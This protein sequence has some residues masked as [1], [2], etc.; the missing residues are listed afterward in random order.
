MFETMFTENA[1][2]CT[3][4]CYSTDRRVIYRSDTSVISVDM[5][6][7]CHR[8]GRIIVGF[9]FVQLRSQSTTYFRFQFAKKREDRQLYEPSEQNYKS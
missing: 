2:Q 7:T 4:G 8:N 5:V 3:I 9:F 6:D 1:G